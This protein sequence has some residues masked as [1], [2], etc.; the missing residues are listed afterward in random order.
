MRQSTRTRIKITNGMRLGEREEHM[1]VKDKS[2]QFSRG[3][4]VD[5]MK[6]ATLSNLY[7]TH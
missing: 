1:M 3:Q 7:K 4:I 5:A 2:K 6:P